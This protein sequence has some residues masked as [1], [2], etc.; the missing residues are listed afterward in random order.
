MSMR[1]VPKIISLFSFPSQSAL[2]G[3]LN[4]ME[5]RREEQRAWQGWQAGR[6]VKEEEVEEREEGERLG[7]R[8]LSEGR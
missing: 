5:K 8:F 6:Q 4:S 7:E 3:W 1:S 2:S